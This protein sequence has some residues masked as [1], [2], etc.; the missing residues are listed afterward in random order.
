MHGSRSAHPLHE[1]VEAGFSGHANAPAHLRQCLVGEAQQVVGEE[2]E[3]AIPK[4]RLAHPREHLYEAI[5]GLHIDPLGMAKAEAIGLPFAQGL[6]PAV[7]HL[8]TRW[9]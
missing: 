2:Q 9:L 4:V 5:E 7:E 3:V 1:L 6:Q 8:D